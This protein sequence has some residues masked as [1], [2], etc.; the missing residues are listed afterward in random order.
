[1]SPKRLLLS[2]FCL[3]FL[4]ES[5]K[6]QVLKKTVDWLMHHS[7]KDTTSPGQ[8]SFRIYP[9]LA[10]APETKLEI[11]LS[12]L[13]LFQAKKD[14]NNRI[15]ELN[16]FTFFTLEKQYGFWLDNAIYGNKDKWFVL[17]RTRYQR[18][19]LLYFGIG[20]EAVEA[21]PAV[22]DANYF[23]F[24]QR[25]LRKVVPNLFIGPEVDY[26]NLFNTNVEHEIEDPVKDFPIGSEGSSNLGL[27]AAIVYDNRHNVL[28]VRKGFFAELG[29]LNYSD[30]LG[31]K[32]S[33]T[34]INADL[35]GYAPI[36]KRNVLAW[37]AT[38]NFYS[39]D[40]PFNQMALMGGETLMRGYYY[41]RYRDKNMLAGQVEYR[42][43]PFSF[44]KRIGAT[45]FAG[46]AVVAPEIGSFR[47]DNLKLAGGAGLRYLLFPKKDIF[48]RFD[49]G[50]TREGFGFYFFTG[51]AF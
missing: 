33:F 27:G 46:T 48:L 3:F 9:T 49:V 19:P 20:P 14:T 22:I 10:Y 51:E 50:F 12:T 40:V 6:A 18:F 23:V 44:S 29:F 8:P 4:V 38:A 36:N 34:G 15:S 17:G 11:G 39:G 1:M 28:N 26:Q 41:G 25:V 7:I 32:Y 35:R 21:Y 2:A 24:R 37:Q 47:T 43:L 45:I 5:P 31:S 42:L 13:Y 30:N 16:A